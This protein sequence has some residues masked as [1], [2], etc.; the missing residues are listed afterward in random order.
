LI[1][2]TSICR[3]GF[4]FE[5][6][7]AKCAA[8]READSSIGAGKESGFQDQWVWDFRRIDKKGL[9]V[10]RLFEADQDLKSRE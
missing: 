6:R 8:D 5:P 7:I 4:G 1:V 3:R 10:I 2:G 9:N